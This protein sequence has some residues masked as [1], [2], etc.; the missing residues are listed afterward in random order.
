MSVNQKAEKTALH[1]RNI[2]SG[3]QKVLHSYCAVSLYHMSD[4]KGTT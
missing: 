4:R 1:G 3:I 2:Q